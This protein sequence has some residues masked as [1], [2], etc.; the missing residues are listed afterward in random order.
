MKTAKAFGIIDVIA[1]IP[2]TEPEQIAASKHNVIDLIFDLPRPPS[3]NRL[4]ARLGNK[5]NI[6][7][8]W[9]RAADARL[10]S[11]P[12]EWRRISAG[13]ITGPFVID[14]TWHREDFGRFDV[15]NPIKCLMDYLQRIAL[16]E[17]DKLCRVMTVAFGTAP[18]GCRVR[19]RA[20]DWQS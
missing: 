19:L 18:D 3:V 1:R 16:I 20:W 17:N 2:P 10:M 12:H 13:K 15:D 11:N 4:T 9:I 7:Q 14:I 5:S 8:R 6:V